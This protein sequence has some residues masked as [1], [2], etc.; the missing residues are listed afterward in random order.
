MEPYQ[1]SI[2]KHHK[3]TKFKLIGT[4]GNSYTTDGF[5]KPSY[6]R[7]KSAPPIGE[8]LE[9]TQDDFKPKRTL[10]PKFWQNNQ[11]DSTIAHQL[12]QIALDFINS[13]PFE[14][15]P[16]DITL[17][18][19]IANFHWS[20]ESDIDLHIILNFSKLSKIHA[21]LIKDYF[22]SKKNE[23]NSKHNILINQHEVELYVQD[24]LEPHYSTAVWSILRNQWIVEPTKSKPTIDNQEIQSKVSQFVQQINNLET[25]L[26]S[27]EFKKANRNAKQLVD[28]L[29]RYR[30]IGLEKR[31]EF[32]V[33]NLVFKTLRRGGFIKRLMEIRQEAYDKSMGN[34]EPAKRDDLQLVEFRIATTKHKSGAGL[35]AVNNRTGKVL[36]GKRS[37]NVTNPSVW[38]FP[39]GKVESKETHRNAARR[40]FSEETWYPGTF[41]NLKRVWIQP[42]PFPYHMFIAAIDHFVPHPDQR[43]FAEMMWVD[44]DDFV[45]TFEPKHP[46]LQQMLDDASNI[47]RIKNYMDSLL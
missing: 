19:S 47:K 18:G 14:I 31:G 20:D 15:E 34:D 3:A 16:D 21:K 25:M 33:E 23:W 6:E 5:Q 28:K 38:V 2:Q 40:E 46:K 4:G 35:I 13:L 43:E 27:K 32:A 29:K 41:Q 8:M 17:T 24:S 42:K 44:F 22:N 10:Y 36:V 45:N 9:Y 12:E 1:K 37:Q 39:G 30:K 11:L 7:S 26:S